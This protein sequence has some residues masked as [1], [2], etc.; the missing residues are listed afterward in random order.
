MTGTLSSRARRLEAAADLGDF[1]DAVGVAAVGGGLHQLQVVHDQQVQPVLGLEAASLGPQLHR[2][3]VGR[4]VDEDRR[5]RK[6][7][8]RRR[9]AGE[10]QLLQEAGPQPL[11]VDRGDAR[12]QA[13]DQLLLAHLQAE[14]ADRLALANGRVLGDVER[15]AGLAD[16]GPGGQDDQVAGLEAGGQLVQVR[17][18]RG[19][20]DDLAAVGVQVVQPVVGVVEERSQRAEA[21]RRTGAG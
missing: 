10:V 2:A 20:A 13:Q 12:Q 18:A 8:H 5:V 7:L 15:E 1:L 11:R 14:D 17:E 9:D 6:G 21:R 3:D 4:V 19:D 16:A